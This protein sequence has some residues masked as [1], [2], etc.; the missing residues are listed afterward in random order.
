[1]HLTGEEFPADCLG[2]RELTRRLLARDLVLEVGGNAH[3]LSKTRVAGA[4][5]LDMVA[6][7]NEKHR[8][9]FQIA[10]GEGKAA[11]RLAWRTWRANERWN[12]GVKEW[13]AA[14]ERKAAGRFQRSALAS[15]VPA[16]APHPKLVGEVRPEWD[17][18]SALYNTDAQILSDAGIPVVLLMEN[19]D[20][21]RAG[22]HDS[23]DT[24]A[25]I[26]LDYGAA[27]IAIAIETV[28]D[29]ATA[30]SL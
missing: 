19:Y 16:I 21:R 17:P 18:R 6:H 9:V 14:P 11:A 22:Y 27:L 29:C 1:V 23:Q 24:M 15:Q 25:N 2:A 8:D 12:R 4:F 26:D 5:V 3:D 30:E 7:N 20:I 28:A 10:P 13:N